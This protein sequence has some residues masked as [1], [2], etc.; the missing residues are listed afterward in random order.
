[1]PVAGLVSS[2]RNVD[3]VVEMM[4]DFTQNFKKPL[5]EERLFGWHAALFPTDYSGMCKIEF[6]LLLFTHLMTEMD[7]LQEQFQICYWLEVRTVRT[8]L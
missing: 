2:P 6:D 3:R 4:L 5:T 7:E 8:V 1:L